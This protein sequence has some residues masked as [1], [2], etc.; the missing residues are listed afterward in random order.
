MHMFWCVF[1]HAIT[2][3]IIERVN[4]DTLETTPTHGEN[5]RIICFENLAMPSMTLKSDLN[6]AKLIF[7]SQ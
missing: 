7:G 4:G 1:Q 2:R 3:A 5:K 6:N